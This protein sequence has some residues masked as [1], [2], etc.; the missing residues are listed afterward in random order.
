MKF[1]YPFLADYGKDF[2]WFRT[3]GPGLANC[4]FVAARAYS[5]AKKYDAEFIDPTWFKLSVGPYIRREKDKRHYLGLFE[6][7]GITG[8]KKW[9]LIH[10][11]THTEKELK[12]FE[13]AKNGVLKVNTLGNYFKDINPQDAKEYFDRAIK[14]SIK[15]VV[16]K[17]DFSLKIA[18]HV[19][20]GDYVNYADILT[21]IEWYVKVIKKFA[22]LNPELEFCVFSDGTDEQLEEI[23]ALPNT[24]RVFYGSALADIY[25]ISQ[26]QFVVAS[27]STFSAWGAFMGHKPIVFHKCG[28]MPIYNDNSQIQYVLGDFEKLP[29]DVMDFIKTII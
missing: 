11:V 23:L 22:K 17:D 4:M 5:Y 20:L 15:D 3:G 10:K 25:A 26:C 28:F 12:A 14:H 16:L 29:E 21:P 24:H 13:I 9:S 27:H 6:Q 8:M 7:I 2:G 18:V 1:V 19:R